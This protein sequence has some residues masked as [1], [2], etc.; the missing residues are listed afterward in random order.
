M[1]KT[2]GSNETRGKAPFTDADYRSLAKFRRA[3]RTFLYFSEQAAKA[4]GVTPSQHQ[5]MLAIRGTDT[6]QPPTIGEVAGW[7]KLR[8]HSMVELADRA[9]AAGLVK[10]VQDTEDQRRQ[11]LV[12]TK[13]GEGKLAQ[14]SSIHREELRRF[15]EEGFG[16][17]DS[18]L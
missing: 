11:R 5:L 8:H 15:R 1:P 17:P 12:L 4:A 9:E 6:G 13:Q 2:A 7:M 18:L 14:L 16:Q 3:L 10:R